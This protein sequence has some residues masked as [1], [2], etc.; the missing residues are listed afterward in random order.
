MRGEQAIGNRQHLFRGG[1]LVVAFLHE[2]GWVGDP[3]RTVRQDFAL[4]QPPLGAPDSERF[5]PGR[6][7]TPIV[8]QRFG[9]TIGILIP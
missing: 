6:L 1:F 9:P 2:S 3:T 5:D 4:K 8:A 7:Q